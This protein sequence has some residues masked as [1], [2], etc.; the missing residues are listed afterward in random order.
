M[1]AYVR[2]ATDLQKLNFLVE[3]YFIGVLYRN[4]LHFLDEYKKKLLIYASGQGD[5][6]EINLIGENL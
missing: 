4:C 1:D 5:I 3:I 2:S 6:T